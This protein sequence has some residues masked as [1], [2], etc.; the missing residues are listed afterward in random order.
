MELRHGSPLTT[1]HDRIATQYKAMKLL[2]ATIKKTQ[3]L[4]QA[5]E[6]IFNIGKSVLLSF[7][8]CIFPN[9]PLT[10]IPRHVFIRLLHCCWSNLTRCPR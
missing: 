8:D 6:K 5:V 2:R 4:D 3:R 7:L 9:C 10:S 1:L